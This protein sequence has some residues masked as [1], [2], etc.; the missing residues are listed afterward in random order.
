MLKETETEETAGFFVSFWHWGH[1][2]WRGGPLCSNQCLLQ[3]NGAA[4]KQV[5]KFKHLRVA[6]TSVRRQDDKFD[7]RI[8]KAS[9]ILRSYTL[10]LVVV[11]RE[12]S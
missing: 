6:F 8:G 9:A 1:F 11:K 5:Q 10:Y 4:L 7:T 2:N 3:V 12:L